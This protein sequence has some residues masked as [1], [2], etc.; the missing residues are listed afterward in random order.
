MDHELELWCSQLAQWANVEP[1]IGE[2]WI[3]GS[4]ARGDNGPNSDLDVAV[5]MAD[6][7]K[8]TRYG[9]WAFLSD[10]WKEELE[11]FLPIAIDLDIGDPDISTKVVGPAVKKDGVC[12]FRRQ[13]G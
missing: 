10:D 5:I 6:G 4:R 12:I 9:N 13:H 7:P 3:F 1:H 2:L 8:G 11:H